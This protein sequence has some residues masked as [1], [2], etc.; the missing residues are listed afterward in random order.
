MRWMFW[1]KKEEPELPEIS[2]ADHRLISEQFE[3]VGTLCGYGNE[4][5]MLNE[6]QKV[7]YITQ[8]LEMEVNN[9]GFEQF[10]DNSS[11]DFTNRMLADLETLGAQ[12]II[13]IYK[14]AIAAYGGSLPED[15][16]ARRDFLDSVSERKADR[17]SGILSQCDEAFYAAELSFIA[18]TAAY[19]K[20][21]QPFFE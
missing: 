5:S 17:I 6:P 2:E 20:K 16:D 13:P 19:L 3:K 10:F 21:N 9:G 7:F 8:L 18:A 15:W 11:G 1:K 12:A 14:K 4:L